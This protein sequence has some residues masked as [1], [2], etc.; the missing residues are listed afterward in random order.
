MVENSK[1]TKDSLFQVELPDGTM[2]DYPAVFVANYGVEPFEVQMLPVMSGVE[3][4][5]FL[6]IGKLLD[7]IPN[8]DSTITKLIDARGEGKEAIKSI[9]VD[10]I[11]SLV[12]AGVDSAPGLLI[13]LGA[14]LSVL[15]EDEVR[16]RLTFAD[17]VSMIAPVFFLEKYRFTNS[18][19][20]ILEGLG[21]DVDEIDAEEPEPVTMDD[22][23]APE[24]KEEE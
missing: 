14:A 18:L 5:A 1:S 10:E 6:L 16:E 19:G 24:A 9:G 2:L 21:Y 17:L 7:A 12:R 15:D 11:I 13:E 3:E 22:M 23:I 4:Q 20:D 8:L